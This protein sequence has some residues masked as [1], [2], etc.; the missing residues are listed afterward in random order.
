MN[1]LYA[2]NAKK[3]PHSAFNAYKEFT[4]KELDGLII[5]AAM[6]EFKMKLFDGKII[7]LVEKMLII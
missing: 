4:D 6:N 3:G 7:S 1:F 2:S 5:A